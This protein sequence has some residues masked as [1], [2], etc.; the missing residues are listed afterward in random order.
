[1]LDRTHHGQ[2]G[3]ARCG[4]VVMRQHYRSALVVGVGDG[5]SASVAR[6]FAG[7]GMRIGLAA[8]NTDKLAAL[9]SASKAETFGCDATRPADV[10]AMFKAADTALGGSPEVVL[11]NP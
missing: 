1:M 4:E 10:E 6:A 9:A 11:Y 2:I 5:L 8:R 7:A 3:K